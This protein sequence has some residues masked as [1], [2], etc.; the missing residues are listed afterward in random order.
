MKALYAGSFD[1]FTIG[2]LDI[3]EKALEMFDSLIIG[4]GYNESKKEEWPVERRVEAIKKIFANRKEVEVEAYK[5][6]TVEFAKA[7]GAGVLVRGVRNTLDFEKEKE[8]A[9]INKIVSG[10]NT[11]MIPAAPELSYISSSMVRELYHN[12]YDI[13]RFIPADN[14]N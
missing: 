8:L 3:A 13:T 10:I 6:L 5:G 9:D 12:G 1:P 11:V 4:I 14:N 2:H 7:K